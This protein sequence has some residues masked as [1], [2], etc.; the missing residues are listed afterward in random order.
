MKAATTISKLSKLINRVPEFG[1]GI[2][3]LAIGSRSTVRRSSGSHPRV[4]AKS[5]P[6]SQR[7]IFFARHGLAH[8]FW[9]SNLVTA[10]CLEVASNSILRQAPL[11]AEH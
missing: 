1:G 7:V 4:L 2:I 9:H 3:K 10:N 5:I 11:E 8:Y 6:H